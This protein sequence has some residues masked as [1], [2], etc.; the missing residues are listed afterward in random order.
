MLASSARMWED[1]HAMVEDG[2]A[3]LRAAASVE[4]LHRLL[5]TRQVGG[6][7]GQHQEAVELFGHHHGDDPGGAVDTAVLLCTEWRWYGCT[8]KLIV[9]VCA[10][11]ILDD[12]ALDE[13]ADRL[14]WPDRPR[15]RHPLSWLGLEWAARGLGDRMVDNERPR[16][17][18]PLLRWAAGHL[19]RRQRTD[20]HRL[21]QRAASL[22]G[23]DSS[24]VTAG[25][26]DAMDSLPDA[27]VYLAIDHGLASGRAQIRKMALRVFADRV[28]RTEGV[29]RAREDPDR[30]IRRWAPELESRTAGPEPTTLP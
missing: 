11:G 9:G 1:D 16:T 4:E 26:L 14:L 6:R 25:M 3:E 7:S 30:S 17:R 5:V 2:L 10:T 24:S 8:A 13:L 18:P 28:D 15:V 19:L 20:L 21:R 23:L 22:D 29:R 12:V 27:D